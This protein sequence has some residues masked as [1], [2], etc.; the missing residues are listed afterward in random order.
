[1]ADLWQD[2]AACTGTDPKL[3]FPTSS[4]PTAARAAVGICH[5]CPVAA[6][7]LQYAID[8]ELRFGVFGGTTASQRAKMRT[9]RP[10]SKMRKWSDPKPCGSMAAWRRHLRNKE[11]IDDLCRMAVDEYNAM[12]R[13][14]RARLRKERG[15]SLC[16]GAGKTR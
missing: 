10:V 2:R 5:T 9:G 6:Q 12:V 15:T 13:A 4:D 14:E 7:C 11:P 16:D 8:E 3:W 1:M